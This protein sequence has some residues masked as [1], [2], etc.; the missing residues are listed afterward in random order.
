MDDIAGDFPQAKSIPASGPKKSTITV[1][2][3]PDG[4]TKCLDGRAAWMIETPVTIL[5]DVATA[6]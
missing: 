3:E 1:R 5:G 4:R 2:I 6:A